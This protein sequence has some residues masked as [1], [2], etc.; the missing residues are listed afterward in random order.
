M[1]ECVA[2]LAIKKKIITDFKSIQAGAIHFRVTTQGLEKALS[3]KQ[4]KIPKYL[5]D[6][7][8]LESVTT[9]HRVG[10]S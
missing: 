6:Y 1:K 4:A 3:G 2:L 10:N 5:L 9:Y 8:G 7:A